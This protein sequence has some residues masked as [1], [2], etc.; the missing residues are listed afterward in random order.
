[1]EYDR[2]HGLLR[3]DGLPKPKNILNELFNPVY[4]GGSGTR[5]GDLRNYIDVFTIVLFLPPLAPIYQVYSIIWALKR[6][7]NINYPI[8]AKKCFSIVLYAPLGLL[9]IFSLGSFIT[10]RGLA[11]DSFVLTLV[12]VFIVYEILFSLY[13][14]VSTWIFWSFFSLFFRKQKSIK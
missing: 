3:S 4:I 12:A 13:F 5:S 11:I 6:K 10:N 8:I 7:I 9:F 2:F 14:A 1:M